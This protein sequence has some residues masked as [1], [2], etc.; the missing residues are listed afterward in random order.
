MSAGETI[1]LWITD[2]DGVATVQAVRG[3]GLAEIQKQRFDI[4]VF[5]T[6]MALGKVMQGRLAAHLN[7][8][9]RAALVEWLRWNW[10]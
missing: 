7:D 2:V 5:D 6:A 3:I 9:Q 10:N 8:V 4:V 1:G